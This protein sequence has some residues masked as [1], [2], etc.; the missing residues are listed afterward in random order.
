MSLSRGI[1]LFKSIKSITKSNQQI[2][3]NASHGPWNYR[4]SGIER[5]PPNMKLAGDMLM[6]FAVWWILWHVWHEP[7]HIVG[8]FEYPDP[9][10]WTDA[11]LG[12][13]P[14]DED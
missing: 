6:G 8:E 9:S 12:I 1:C 13:P 3:R 11:E 2:I 4:R 10:K 5:V 14:D 7:G